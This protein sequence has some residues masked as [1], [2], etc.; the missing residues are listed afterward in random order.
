MFVNLW[1]FGFTFIS[2]N[3]HAVLPGNKQCSL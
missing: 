2:Q 1:I 3:V